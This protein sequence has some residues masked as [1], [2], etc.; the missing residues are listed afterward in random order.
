MT[1]LAAV[2]MCWACRTKEKKVNPDTFVRMARHFS[3]REICGI[4]WL[5][6]TERVCVQC[7]MGCPQLLFH[8]VVRIEARGDFRFAVQFLY[9]ATLQGVSTFHSF[10][11]TNRG[12]QLL[13]LAC[14]PVVPQP[15]KIQRGGEKNHYWS[16]HRN[17][18]WNTAR[19]SIRILS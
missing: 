17:C 4:V 15:A 9:D 19:S 11:G 1:M 13:V 7:S 3:E 10:P 12:Q 16:F 18:V 14:T 6:A 5:V 8:R 2:H